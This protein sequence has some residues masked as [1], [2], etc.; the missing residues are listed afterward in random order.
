MLGVCANHGRPEAAPALTLQDS[1]RHVP[2]SKPVKAQSTAFQ[3]QKP[4]PVERQPLLW[5]TVAYAAGIL[6][7]A[8][9]WRPFVWWLAAM[10][11]LAASGVYLR[12]HRVR[13]AFLIACAVLF[14]IG[15]VTI[16]LHPGASAMT[17]TRMD[18]QDVVIT[19]HVMR[20]GDLR[21]K[22]IADIQQ[23]VD[24]ETEQIAT[25][26]QVLN[27]HCG[28]RITIYSRNEARDPGAV[29]FFR[30]GERLR[31]ATKLSRPRNFRN[32]GSFDYEASLAE[33]GIVALASSKAE[34]VEVLPGFAGRR[35]ELWRT[36]IYHSLVQQIQRLWP[37]SEAALMDAMLIGDNAFVRRDLLT[38][39]QRTGTYHVLVISGLK[40]GILALVTFWLLRRLRVNSLVSSAITVLLTLAYALLTDVGAPVWRATLMLTLYLCAKALYRSRAVLNTIAAAALALL[41]IDPAALFGASFQ[42]SFLCVLI[43]AGIGT[44]ILQRTTQPISSAVRNLGSTT[45]DFALPPKLVQFRLDLRMIAEGL[46]RFLGL[47]LSLLI[48]RAT[49]RGLTLGCEFLLI[50]L[51]LQIGFTLP[52]AYYFHRATIVSLPANVLAVPL[53]EVAL[54]AS[55]VAITISYVSFSLAKLPAMIAGLSVQA[56]A[57]SVRWLGALRIADTRVPTPGMVLIIVSAAAL[58]LAMI[59]A[60]RRIGLAMFGVAV[61]SGSALWICFVPPRPQI[62]TGVL[63]IT[64]IDVGQGDSILLVSPQGRTML[65]DAGGIP[66]WMHSEL[67]IGED[68]VSPYLWSRGFH[69]LDAVAVTHPH[70]DHIG[71]MRAIL[72]NFHPQELWLSIGPTNSE[73]ESLIREAASLNIPIVFH[74]A[75]DRFESGGLGFRV[76][77]PALDRET[78]STKSNDDSLVISVSY[79]NTS[80]LLEGDAEKEVERRIAEE[81]V[82]ADLLKVGHHGSATSTIPELLSAVRPHFAVISVGAHNVYGHPRREVLQRLADA[83]IRTYRTDLNG[84]VSFYLD[85]HAVIPS[86]A[87]LQSR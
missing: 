3:S 56:M 63:E 32:P 75:G 68:V 23:R 13:T 54:V 49:I 74:Q 60:R 46:Q 72:A 59:L 37:G 35:A 50:S 19:G 22:G 20:E 9:A 81:Q 58:T 41:L 65:I 87:A 27:S 77:A 30:Y 70:A 5:A 52:M 25:A 42:L 78:R 66:H 47:R 2:A 40:V 10:L 17:C 86:L 67:D 57:G 51:V 31:F 28:I 45:Y 24:L 69:Q 6:F 80:A 62:R 44:P 53:T 39:F 76:L 26:S 1:S 64:S 33:Q 14:S 29:R 4:R 73:S 55:I 7:G 61:L 38:D 84:A 82:G 16:Q 12:R 34:N 83:H 79:G 11:V 43:I 71:G 85:G 18:G 48:L 8:Y 15:A 36:R 21:H